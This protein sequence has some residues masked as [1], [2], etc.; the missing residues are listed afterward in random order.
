MTKAKN[1]TVGMFPFEDLAK[2][3]AENFAEECT[4]AWG[5]INDA[6]E[7]LNFFENSLDKPIKT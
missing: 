3:Y 2:Q 1:L 4:Y 5:H 7:H 6:E